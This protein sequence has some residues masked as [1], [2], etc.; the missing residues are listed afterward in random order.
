MFYTM[1][2]LLAYIKLFEIQRYMHVPIMISTCFGKD[3]LGKGLTRKP[4]IFIAS[5]WFEKWWFVIKL[6]FSM[7]LMVS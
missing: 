1:K 4:C 6:D 7:F 3:V 5:R 2:Y